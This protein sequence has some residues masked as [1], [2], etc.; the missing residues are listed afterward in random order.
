MLSMNNGGNVLAC[1]N[2][3]GGS[4]SMYRIEDGIFQ[5]TT[6]GEIGPQ[7]AHK[8]HT[9][10]GRDRV[11]QRESHVHSLVFSPDN[12]FILASDLGND[13]VYSYYFDGTDNALLN[14]IASK[15]RIF[16]PT[17]GADI[18]AEEHVHRCDAGSGPRHVTFHPDSTHAYVV[19]ELSSTIDYCQYD[20]ETGFLT[21]L[22]SVGMLPED[23]EAEEWT[24]N[25]GKWAADIAG[26]PSG[27]FLYA[28]NRLHNSIVAFPLEEGIPGTPTWYASCGVTP[29]SFDITHDGKIMIVAHQHSHDIITFL[30][31]CDEEG[32]PTTGEPCQVDPRFGKMVVPCAS[33]VKSV[34]NDVMIPQVSAE[35]GSTSVSDQTWGQKGMKE[36]DYKARF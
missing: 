5:G 14:D 6:V 30:I 27:K 21:R 22:G 32:I 23:Y 8:V 34:H 24:S 20:K 10:Y 16:D 2:Y 9:G 31:D 36:T 1:A 13:K 12:Q 33:C 4:F 25:W 17:L 15:D 29:R 3:S 11:R 26:H 18:V 7:L 19:H 28:T 35:G